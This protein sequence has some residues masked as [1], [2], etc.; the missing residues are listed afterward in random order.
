MSVSVSTPKL[1]Y[2]IVVHC[3]WPI[4]K[5]GICYLESGLLKV[6]IRLIWEEKDQF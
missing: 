3:K 4:E 1:F 6:E 2:T 5:I